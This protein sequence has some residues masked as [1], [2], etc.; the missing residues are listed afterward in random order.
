MRRSGRLL[1]LPLW[2]RRPRK[3]PQ[4]VPPHERA[5][6]EPFLRPGDWSG[7]RGM[8]SKCTT[9]CDL[10]RQLGLS[11]AKIKILLG[12]RARNPVCLERKLRNQLDERPEN[13]VSRERR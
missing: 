8:Q 3:T 11:E 9:V 2:R 6:A 10:A 5:Q 13:A 1:P 4:N 7:H 12:Q